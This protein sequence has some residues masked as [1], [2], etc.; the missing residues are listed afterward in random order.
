MPIEFSTEELMTETFAN[1]EKL[2]HLAEPARKALGKLTDAME[3]EIAGA[4]EDG[5]AQRVAKIAWTYGILTGAI[6]EIETHLVCP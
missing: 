6:T 5:D 2:E 4:V 3:D 1:R